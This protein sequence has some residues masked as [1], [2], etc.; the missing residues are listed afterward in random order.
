MK[1]VTVLVSAVVIFAIAVLA[2]RKFRISSRYERT[3]RTRNP[4]RDLDEGID[5]SDES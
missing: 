3:P 5:P 1:L 2:G 4:W